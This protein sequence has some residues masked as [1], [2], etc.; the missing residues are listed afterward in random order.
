MKRTCLASVSVLIVALL[1]LSALAAPGKPVT[2][3]PTGLSGGG[4]MF[5]P[6][7]SPADPKMMMV[8]CDMSAAYVSHDGGRSWKMVNHAQLRST[9]RCKPAFHPTD[10]KVIFSAQAGP[11]KVSRDGGETWQT[12]QGCPENLC[13]QIAIDAGNPDRM[14]CGDS[15]GVYLSGDGGKKWFACKGPKGETIAFAFDQTSPDN[16]RVLFAATA[17]GVWRSDDGGKTWNAK[18]KGLP[19]TDVKAFAG[20]S[21][22]KG[23]AVMLYCSV[24][25][26][27]EGGKHN[28]GVYVSSDRGETWV[29]AMGQ[30]I[31]KDTQK[32]DEWGM[33]DVAQYVDLQTSDAYPS[34]VW[35]V[36]TNTGVKPPHHTAVF[37]SDD[38][39]KNWHP[40]FYPDP[41]FKEYNC[42]PEYTAVC[43]GQYYQSH[44]QAACD[45]KNP[46]HLLLISGGDVFI[47]EDGGKTWKCGNTHRANAGRGEASWTCTGLVV[48]TTWNYYVDPTDPKRHYIG[49]TDIGF[50]R[51]LDGGQSWIWWDEKS[52]T[53]WRNTCYELAFDP[54]APGKIWG[55]FSNT[56]DIPNGNI[57]GGNHKDSYPGG[58]CLSTDAGK[59][60]KPSAQGLPAAACLSVVMD[61]KSPPGNRTLYTSMFN[62]GVYK[63]TDDG[64]SWAK[65]SDGLGDPKNMRCCRLVLHEDGTLFVVITAMRKGGSYLD[66]G[67]GVWRSKDGAKTW[68]Q[69][70]KSQPLLWPKDITVDPKNSSIVYV[71]AADAG[72]GQQGGLYR[73]TDGGKDWSLLC[74]KGPQ[75][76]GAYLHPKRPGWIYAT[77]TEGAPGAGLWLSKDD[78]K[79][80]KPINALPFV[81]AQRVTVDPTD[82]N[83]IYVATF[84]GSVWRGPADGT[85]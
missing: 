41:R 1:A 6:A 14:L 56:H 62:N 30:G 50:A 12:L 37:R 70:N 32:A 8:H 21:S 33:G 44:M 15:R 28:G 25:A 47:T 57:I 4:A 55:A 9:T 74:R 26:K 10:P 77:L 85:E 53:Q 65:A 79:T 5:S 54:K 52:K 67:A 66:E 82:D 11:T 61:P 73:T 40:T 7:V 63:S 39:G 29:S 43:D 17:E 81:N 20:A 72:R 49:Y 22:A 42:E 35:A 78:G 38:A 36:N 60:W 59:S 24:T 34:S 27:A 31:N 76:F 64:R 16:S 83:V 3:E 48:T 68:E 23:K 13:G 46:D 69:I 71:G 45:A 75:H 2:W 80:W 19:W 84:G 51:S 58:V 18:T